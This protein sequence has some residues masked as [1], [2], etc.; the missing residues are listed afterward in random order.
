[1]KAEAA[2]AN[3]LEEE[4]VTAVSRG[5]DTFRYVMEE[6]RPGERRLARDA[7]YRALDKGKILMTIERKLLVPPA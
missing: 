6:I 1:M 4:V 5:A 2:R 7:F 3:R